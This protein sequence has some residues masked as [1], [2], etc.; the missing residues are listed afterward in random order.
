[1]HN[2]T[3]EPAWTEPPWTASFWDTRYGSS[4]RVWSGNPNPQLVREVVELVP[5]SALDAGCGEGGDAL[6]LARH[7]WRVTALDI[8]P[9]ALQRGA[10]HAE[11]E[12]ADR[13]VWRQVDLLEWH[14]DGTRYDL[15]SAHFLQLPGELR[16]PLYANL[17]AA[18]APGGTLL[19]VGH[20]PGDLETTAH[21]PD[22]P[23]LFFTA[24]QMAATLDP[25][26]WEILV[27]DARP[28]P[29]TDPDGREITISDAVL[30]ARRRG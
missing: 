13:I 5:G 27:T 15:V 28:R 20:H 29:A 16:E 8:S 3:T 24:E 26:Q 18:V 11:P 7:G 10:A 6:W 21:R 17:A 9:I 1:M 19:V 12:I 23:E 14:P 2:H 30:R 4:Q 25:E 22:A